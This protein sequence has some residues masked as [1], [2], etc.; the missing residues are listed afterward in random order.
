MEVKFTEAGLDLA[1]ILSELETF[2]P[3]CSIQKFTQ[4]AVKISELLLGFVESTHHL[5]KL[6]KYGTP[7]AG[8]LVSFDVKRT[9]Y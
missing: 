5:I 1:T 6:P 2:E 9:F 4:D 8:F 7:E 3:D